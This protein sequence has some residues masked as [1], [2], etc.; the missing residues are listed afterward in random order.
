MANPDADQPLRTRETA[1]G[2]QRFMLVRVAVMM[3][4]FLFTLLCLEI[5]LRF[6]P[7]NEGLRTLPVNEANPVAR[8]E[9]NRDSTWSQGW[10][11]HMVNELHTNNFGFVSDQDYDP[12]ATT[13]L[14]AVIGDSYV[15]ASM[16]PWPRTSAGRLAAHLEEQARVYAFG[17]SGAPLSQY[18]VYAEYAHE[19]FRPDV[20]VVM[21]AGNDFDES[22]RKYKRRAGF[23]YFVESAD[24]DLELE[25]IDFSIGPV[26]K[27]VRGSV[28][29]MYLVGNLQI[30]AAPRRLAR[31]LQGG[32]E[33]FVGSTAFDA[34]PERVSDSKRAVD[35]FLEL[36]PS[37][38]G[39]APWSILL[40]VDGM[41]PHLYDPSM[42]EQ[43]KGSF[44]QVMRDYLIESASRAGPSHRGSPAGVR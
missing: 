24:G 17:V 11:F 2:W 18:L 6:L 20:M 42:L 7:V 19:L 31:A 26:R 30:Q 21:I 3:L 10:R 15:Q 23:H 12:E 40:V 32:D 34:N 5:L 22:L 36:L 8:F 16:L 1:P 39:L 33:V 38:A 13:P 9:P 14:L 43:A 4:S 25:R 44:V 29:A 41:R 37:R 35:A 28:L 27:M